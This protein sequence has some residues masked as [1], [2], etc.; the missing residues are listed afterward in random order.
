MFKSLATVAALFTAGAEAQSHQQFEPQESAQVAQ[1]HENG[2]GNNLMNLASCPSAM[3]LIKQGEGFRSCVY[4]DTMGIPTICYGFNLQGKR[5]QVEATGAN[6]DA[7]LSGKQCL[8]ENVCTKLLQQEYNT[9]SSAAH[10]I[11]GN[12]SCPCAMNVVTDMTYNLGSGG[13]RSFTTF[14]SLVKSGKY[15]EAAA[16]GRGTAWCRQVGS[17][18]S[19]NMGILASC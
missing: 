9:A 14:N 17:R 11:F 6:Y 15:S 7:V 10:S 1:L 4:K 12:L 3:D 13:M 2:I 5:S 16:D 8:N 19:R 18:C